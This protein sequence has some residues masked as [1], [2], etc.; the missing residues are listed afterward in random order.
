M[1]L[2]KVKQVAEIL[3]VSTGTVYNLIRSGA[4]PHRR[5]GVLGGGIRIDREDVDG[6]LAVCLVEKTQPEK[7]AKVRREVK[8]FV[9]LSQAG[10][11][12]EV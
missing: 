10:Y 6:Y 12:P 3:N 9:H 7:P 2:L 8:G 11:C 4:I 5:I 1:E